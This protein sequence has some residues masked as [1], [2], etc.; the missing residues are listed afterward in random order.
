M[1]YGLAR[2]VDV[3]SALAGK[4][5]FDLLLSRPQARRVLGRSCFSVTKGVWQLS[6]QMF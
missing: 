2:A 6:P 1:D 4:N 5:Y 3:S